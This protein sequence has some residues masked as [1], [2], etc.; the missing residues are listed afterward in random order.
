MCKPASL[1]PALRPNIVHLSEIPPGYNLDLSKSSHFRVNFSVGQAA[2]SALDPSHNEFFNLATDIVPLVYF[3]AEALRLATTADGGSGLD[4][5]GGGAA[6]ALSEAVRMCIFATVLQHATSLFSHTFSCCSPR[7]SRTVKHDEKHSHPFW[8]ALETET[9]PPLAVP[10]FT[11]G[12][13]GVW[14][15]AA[16]PH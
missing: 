6:P 2:A 13:V 7:A 14:T 15:T 9:L 1:K 8:P 10:G 11:L 16:D 4:R 5:G 3:S 12:R